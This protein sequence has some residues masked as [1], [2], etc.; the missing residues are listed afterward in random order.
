MNAL[1]GYSSGTKFEKHIALAW[2][3][4]II[5]LIP[6]I[7]KIKGT[8]L[9]PTPIEPAEATTNLDKSKMIKWENGGKILNFRRNTK[10]G[11]VR[12]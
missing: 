10:K 9:I 2:E 8:T 11:S 1:L 12:I 6:L 3:S 5:I 7:K 4:V